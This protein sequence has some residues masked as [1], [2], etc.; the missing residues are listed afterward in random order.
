MNREY[1]SA[2]TAHHYQA[3]RPPLHSLILEKCL[4]QKQ[5]DVGLDMGCG[6]GQSSLALVPYCRQILAADPSPFML[7]CRIPHQNIQYFR[8]DGNKL[9]KCSSGISLCT[10]AGSWFYAKS[11]TLLN[12][13]VDC[14]N[15]GAVLLLYDFNVSFKSLDFI[16]PLRSDDGYN[17]REDLSGLQAEV[18][19]HELKYSDNAELLVTSGELAHLILSEKEYYDYFAR[20]WDPTKIHSSLTTS[21]NKELGSK[22]LESLHQTICL[23]LCPRLIRLPS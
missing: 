8:L 5:F 4:Q 12:A 11:Q 2:I 16:L 20:S 21:I 18:F 22:I 1:L 7:S 19:R 15:P 13:L 10:F 14:L 3:Y 17:Y 9:P 6:T 23:S